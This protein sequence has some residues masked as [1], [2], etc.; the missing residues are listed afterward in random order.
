MSLSPGIVMFYNDGMPYCFKHAVELA[1]SGLIIESLV[2]I[3]EDSDMDEQVLKSE[4]MRC[5]NEQE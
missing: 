4:C 3:N 2:Y 1:Q 5:D